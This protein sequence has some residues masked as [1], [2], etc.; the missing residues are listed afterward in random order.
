MPHAFS[1]FGT[2]RRSVAAMIALPKASHPMDSI[3][4]RHDRRLGL[5]EG[6]IVEHRRHHRAEVLNS[7]GGGAGV[8]RGGAGGPRRLS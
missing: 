5:L 6:P 3:S 8:P 4:L 2:R 1:P 7:S